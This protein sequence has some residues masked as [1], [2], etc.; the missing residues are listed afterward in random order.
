MTTFGRLSKI[1]PKTPNGTLT[2]FTINPLFLLLV[3]IISDTVSG[4]SL[5][6]IRESIILSIDSCDN[7]IL[8]KI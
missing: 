5:T 1:T 8:S 6:V 3:S 7:L 4:I 2:L